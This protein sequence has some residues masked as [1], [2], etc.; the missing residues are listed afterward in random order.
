M[1][2]LLDEIGKRYRFEW[3][4]KKVNYHFK[5]GRSYALL[6][7]NGSG[8]STF[9]KILTGHLTPTKGH[10]YFEKDGQRI[11]PDAIYRY[12]SMAAPYI[13]LLEELS[14]T[15]ALDFHQKFKPFKEGLTTQTLIELLY[16]ESSAEKPI[17]FFS[18]GMKQRLKLGLALCSDTPIV[19]LDE[20][21]TNLDRE[22]I[23][24]YKKLIHRFGKDRLLVVASNVE[25]DYDFCEER[26][27]VGEWK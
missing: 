9:L 26:V 27:E 21:T 18:S 2:I 7:P 11:K 6:G 3:V 8:K 10:V 13:E 14:L 17:R 15:E 19:F 25:E 5:S 4:F 12:L 23:N 20:P 16:L 1:D 24:W 22:G